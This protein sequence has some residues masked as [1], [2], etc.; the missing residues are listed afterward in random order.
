MD[1]GHRPAASSDVI[2]AM[3]AA[4]TGMGN[5][6]LGWLTYA[7]RHIPRRSFFILSL[8]AQPMTTRLCRS[9]MTARLSQPSG[10][11]TSV[12][13]PAH[14]RLGG[15][16]AKS[17]SRQFAATPKAM[18]AVRRD[19]MLACA[20]RPHPVDPNEAANAALANGEASLLQLHC[21]PRAI[22]SAKAQIILLPNMRQYHHVR[23]L[24]TTD[25]ARPPGPIAAITHLEDM[26]HQLHRLEIPPTMY[27]GE[28][29]GLWLAKN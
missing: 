12:M 16:A 27:K 1:A 14:L 28:P 9:S 3:L 5:A 13:S 26:A 24:P 25:R 18:M 7:H 10:V 4:A 17:P 19:L 21:H 11:Q 22:I 20:N 23:P 29:H 6:A 15:L 2:G 8:T